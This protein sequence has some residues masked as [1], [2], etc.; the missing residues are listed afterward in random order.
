LVLALG[1]TALLVGLT[2]LIRQ[3]LTI[4]AS[5]LVIVTTTL[6]FTLAFQLGPSLLVKL[7]AV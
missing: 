3:T 7:P 5:P 4:L 1:Q 6:Q 2:P